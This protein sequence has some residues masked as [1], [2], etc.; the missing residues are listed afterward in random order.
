MLKEA[1]AKFVRYHITDGG[2]NSIKSIVL[3]NKYNYILV[4]P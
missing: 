4:F 2:S 1:E 3:M